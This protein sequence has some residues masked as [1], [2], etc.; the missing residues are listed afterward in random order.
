ML[1]RVVWKLHP[2]ECDIL[3][4][5][6]STQEKAS[7]DEFDIIFFSFEMKPPEKNAIFQLEWST[8]SSLLD[9]N[10]RKIY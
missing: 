4:K 9:R 3:M 8:V 1:Q 6:M 2:I 7:V 5:M 10:K